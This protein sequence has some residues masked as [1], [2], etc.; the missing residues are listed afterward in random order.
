MFTAALQL[1][2]CVCP[3]ISVRHFHHNWKVLLNVFIEKNGPL[4]AAVMFLKGGKQNSTAQRNQALQSGEMKCAKYK[5][6]TFLYRSN[7]GI[8]PYGV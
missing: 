4:D 7:F 5:Q 3:F 8:F 2:G 6:M 1:K